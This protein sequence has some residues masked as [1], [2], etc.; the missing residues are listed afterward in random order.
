MTIKKPIVTEKT[1]SLYKNQNKVTFEVSFDANKITASKAL[2]EIYQVEV[3]KAWVI[4]R[5]GKKKTDWNVRK[6]IRKSA[7]MKIMLF[8]LKS[9]NKISIFEQ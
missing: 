4:N 5:L 3:E 2:E 6:Q 8:K 7:D 9:G 1:L